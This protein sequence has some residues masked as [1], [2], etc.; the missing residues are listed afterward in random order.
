MGTLHGQSAGLAEAEC[1]KRVLNLLRNRGAKGFQQ[2]FRTFE[3]RSRDR[4]QP[5]TMNGED[6]NRL[7]E[8][9]AS[10]SASHAAVT[11]ARE[12]LIE[13]LGDRMC[14][15]GDGPTPQQ[16]EVLAAARRREAV[17]RRDMARFVAT[18]APASSSTG[19]DLAGDRVAVGAGAGQAEL[20]PARMDDEVA[21]DISLHEIDRKPFDRE[22]LDRFAAASAVR[23][24]PVLDL[25][26]GSGQVARY[27]HE[28]GLQVCGLDLSSG[29]VEAARRH[30]PEI[31]F[32]QGDM[33]RLPF[34][35]ASLGGIVS[36]YS[37]IHLQ[38]HDLDLCLAEMRRVLAPGGR[39]A[40]AF[41]V[42]EHVL[43]QDE[44][45]GIRVDMDFHFLKPDNVLSALRRAKLL[46]LEVSEREP[47][48]PDVEAQTRRCYVLAGVNG[49]G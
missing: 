23:S 29:M 39:V 47:H 49:K 46:V 19:C 45:W 14:G 31:H 30:H 15:S 4:A 38:P 22:F 2:T 6:A 5:A 18:L 43:H 32:E 17:A 42:G 8:L 40:L 3:D 1:C 9:R 24:G 28:R 44:L 48:V 36:F 7:K 34:A 41:H 26:C 35:N 16:L 33:R 20:D 37:I 13:A 12:D 11:L 21:I 10:L 25:G 27:L